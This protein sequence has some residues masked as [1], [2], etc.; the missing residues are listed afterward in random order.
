MLPPTR[1]RRSRSSP[2]EP[3]DEPPALITILAEALRDPQQ[4]TQLSHAQSPD[5]QKP[6]HNQQSMCFFKPLCM[7]CV[8]WR[9]RKLKQGSCY[10]RKN[11]QSIGNEGNSRQRQQR[12][13]RHI[14]KKV[15]ILL[16]E[17]CKFRHP[18]GERG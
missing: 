15:C 11:L 9:N 4:R 14:N 3:L 8:L 6:G 7:Q 10:R 18:W 16:Q 2:S 1:E 17:R 12:G 13:Q 5:S